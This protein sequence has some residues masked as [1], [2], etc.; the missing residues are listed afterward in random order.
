M[1]GKTVSHYRILEKLGGGGMGVVYRAQDLKLRR[2]VALKFLPDELTR[3]ATAVERFEREARAA[4]AINH[5]NICTV[6]EVGEHEGSPYIAMELLEGE[7]LKHKIQ[8]KPL[9]PDTLV[10]LAIQITDALDAAHA[11]GIVHRD[12]KPANLFVT[13]H[14]RSKILDFGLAKLRWAPAGAAIGESNTTVAALQTDPG[15]AMGTPAYMSPEQARGEQSDARS[16]LFSL[17]VVLYQMATGKL[18][19]EGMTTAMVMASILRDTPQPPVK[20]NPELPPAL[21]RIIV[22]TL[23]KDPDLRYQSAA[24]LCVD[25]KRL[26]CDTESVKSV[27]KDV[28]SMPRARW[29]WLL[30]LVAAAMALAVGVYTWLHTQPIHYFEHSQVTVLTTTGAVRSAA[31]SP[32]GKY[33]VYANGSPESPS[34]RLRQLATGVDVE[35][36]PQTGATYWELTFSPDGSYIYYLRYVS[37]GETNDLLRVPVVGGTSRKLIRGINSRVTF[38]PDGKYFAFVD[39]EPSESALR[40]ANLDGSDQRTVATHNPPESFQIGS[41][42]WSPDGKLIAV[43]VSRGQYRHV[44]LLPVNGGPE[45]T[46]GPT[47]W[48]IIRALNWVRDGR[49]LLIAAASQSSFVSQVWAIS[50][51]D[52]RLRR[53]TTDVSGYIDLSLTADSQVMS[54]VRAES[55]SNLEIA[56]ADQLGSPTAGTQV[57]QITRGTGRLGR[58]GL[59]WLRD[60]RLAYAPASLNHDIAAINQ[61]GGGAE[62]ITNGEP[63][64]SGLCASG[65]HSLIFTSRRLDQTSLWRVDL[66]GTNKKLV[67]RIGAGPA[68]SPDGNSVVFTYPTNSKLFKVPAE[69]G[70]PVLVPDALDGGHHAATLFNPVPPDFSPDGNKLAYLGYIP[71]VGREVI[72]APASGGKSIRMFPAESLGPL[73]GGLHWAPNSKAIDYS[74]EQNGADNIWRLPLDGGVPKKL[75]HFDSGHIWQFAWSPDGKKLALTRGPISQDV[76]II[77]NAAPQ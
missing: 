11:R 30:G 59:V 41:V 15:H 12:L 53:I 2:E 42:S 19:F 35:L 61:D 60:G 56:D 13:K 73:M 14:G 3:D 71:P 29:R 66:D 72:I 55:I 46:F 52:E 34:L 16:D 40:I 31:I 76:V 18:P 67:T 43:P 28:G 75:T 50:L 38:S 4:A 57:R 25:L 17:G 39:V 1:T 58:G 8:S 51:P 68:C 69:G 24:D 7:T 49:T 48:L 27:A 22:K 63:V 32:D 37:R 9:S 77:R 33:V 70:Q 26:R 44:S 65:D 64:G 23:A 47:D 5:P 21:G 45:R 36:V 10:D 6:H 74:K 62:A 20:L 54:A